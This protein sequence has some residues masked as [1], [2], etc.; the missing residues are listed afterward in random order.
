M[1]EAHL[2]STGGAG[3]GLDAGQA[4]AAVAVVRRMMRSKAGAL[5]AQ[6]VTEE[7]APGYHSVIARP[8]DLGTIAHSLEAG[9]YRSLGAHQAPAHDQL[10]SM[11]SA[12]MHYVKG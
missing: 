4:A 12:C 11:P 6:P 9:H 1:S 3:E 8:M 10:C 2:L 7:Q 5:F